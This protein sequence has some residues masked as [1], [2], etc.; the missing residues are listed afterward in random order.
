MEEDLADEELAG[1]AAEASGEGTDHW[2][3][4][5]R[6]KIWRIVP[7]SGW[8]AVE[9]DPRDDWLCDYAT[10]DLTEHA[11]FTAACSPDPV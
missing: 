5:D 3:Q 1:D 2:V 6:C 9:A 4:C 11:P 7:E 10:W 8:A